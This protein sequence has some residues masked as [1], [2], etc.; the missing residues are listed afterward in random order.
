MKNLALVT[1]ITT[2]PAGNARHGAAHALAHSRFHFGPGAERAVQSG[3][4]LAHRE[5][6]AVDVYLVTAGY[7]V[8]QDE[9]GV[10]IYADWAIAVLGVSRRKF[11]APLRHLRAMMV[12]Q[13]DGK[14]AAW[15]LVRASSAASI[16]YHGYPDCYGIEALVDGVGVTAKTITTQRGVSVELTLS[17]P[18]AVA[19]G[20]YRHEDGDC[21]EVIPLSSLGRG[22]KRHPVTNPARLARRRLGPVAG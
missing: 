2:H 20:F 17:A 8:G 21:D 18:P 9:D 11:F 13:G 19:A 22:C 1:A 16:G 3:L 4:I 6:G 12:A 14:A 10:D 15:A 7:P 5:C